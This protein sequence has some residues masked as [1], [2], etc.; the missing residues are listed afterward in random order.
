MQQANRRYLRGLRWV[1]LGAAALA[2][3]WL[4]ATHAAAQTFTEAPDLA[5]QVA[6]G[7][8]D[9]VEERL[10]VTPL[11]VEPLEA[12]GSYGGTWRQAMRGGSDNLLER[13]IGYTR[14]VRWNLEWTEIVPD[15][16]ESYTVNDD[17]TEFTFTLRDGHRWSDGAPFTVSDI[18]F[19]YNDVL[20]NRE[21]TPEVPAWLRSGGEP[22]VVEQTG[23]HTVTFRFAAPNGLFLANMATV[24]GSDILAGAPQHWLT[25]FHG[26]HDLDGAMALAEAAGAA[27]WVEHFTNRIETPS[28]WR[29]AGRPVLDPWY[30]TVPYVGTTQ[31]AAERNPYYHKVDPQG[32]Q[33][34]YIDRVTYAVMEDRQAIVL[35]A[36]NGELDMQNRHIET[37]DARPL[38]VQ[39]QER[40]GYRLWIAQPAW[41]NAMLI[42]INQTHQDPVL[43]EV[44]ANRDFRVGLSHA[45]DREELNQLIYAGTARPWQAAPRPDTVLYDEDFAT[46]YTAYD[47][48]LANEHLDRAGLTDRDDEG[49][50]LRPDGER[51]SFSVDVLTSRQFQIDAL[52]VIRGYWQAVGIDMQVRPVERSLAFARLQNNE[53]DANVW[54]GGGGYDLLGL[55]DPKWYMPHEYESSFAAAWGIYYQN[56]DDPN[57]ERPDELALRQQELYEQVKATPDLEGQM[58][59]MQ[60]IVAIARDRFYVIGTNMEPDRVGI[61]NTRM[62][63][64]PD[65]MPNTFFYMTPGPAAAEQ[66]FYE[67]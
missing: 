20:M 52:E 14:L 60:E 21:I 43:R 44:F 25:Q 10:P 46:Q 48:D 36:I 38:L 2:L 62:R 64:V 19:W 47:P 58:A 5:A 17:A 65:F 30:L 41:S 24:R 39:N 59:L 8:L 67:N 27:N 51:L 53:H 56:P 54:I 26:D 49:F 12:V 15:V 37:T 7:T 28:R 13:T 57:A 18:L 3:G 16:A 55:L 29:D 11:V 6:A 34:P 23:E 31:V 63:N 40:G 4:P 66:F 61:V 9:P 1:T 22:V 33:L 45:I 35:M 50:R 32:Q 42:N